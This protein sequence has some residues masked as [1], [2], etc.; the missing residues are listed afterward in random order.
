VELAHCRVAEGADQEAA[1]KHDAQIAQL[2]KGLGRGLR[3]ARGLVDNAI[4]KFG[5]TVEQLLALKAAMGPADAMKFLHNIGKSMGVE[6]TSSA[7]EAR[8]WL[9]RHD[10]GTGAGANR[11]LRKDH[12]FIQRFQANDVRG[13]QGDGTPAQDGLSGRA[14]F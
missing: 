9:Q 10:R 1:V 13:A 4:S 2:K 11:Q 6:A 12:A 8:R 7:T 3:E 14:T 5:M